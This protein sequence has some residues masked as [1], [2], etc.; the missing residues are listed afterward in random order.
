MRSARFH[1]TVLSATL[2]LSSASLCPA[3]A[4]TPLRSPEQLAAD[5]VLFSDAAKLI[6]PKVKLC[7]TTYTAAVLPPF[8]VR[9]FLGAAGKRPQQFEIIEGY[10]PARQVRSSL[11][12]EA[13]DAILR[14][15]PYL[16]PRELQNWAGFWVTISFGNTLP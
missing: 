9:F 8:N 1:L 2:L 12:R 4:L 10:Q 5:E 6:A 16:I 7:F 3:G 15:A 11:E 13:V 14:C